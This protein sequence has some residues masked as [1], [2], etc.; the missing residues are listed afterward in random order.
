VLT[1]GFPEADAE[2]LTVMAT[3]VTQTAPPLPQA[4]TWTVCPPFAAEM[5]F[6]R[7]A[8]LCVTVVALLSSE[9]PIEEMD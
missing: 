5:D 4:F 9:Y 8:P 7:L 3:S 2:V 6:W 1:L